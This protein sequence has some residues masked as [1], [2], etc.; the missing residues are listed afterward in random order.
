MKIL[1]LYAFVKDTD[2]STGKSNE[3]RERV[4]VLGLV[5]EIGSVLS[6]LKKDILSKNTDEDIPEKYLVAGELKE[7]IGDAIWYTIMLALCLDDD[8][9]ANDIFTTDLKMLNNQLTGSKRDDK[10]VQKELGDQKLHSFLDA[11]KFYS[12]KRIPT[13]N[14]Y[15]QTAYHTRRTEK[16]VLRNVCSA[17]LQQLAAQL[18]RDF[19][20]DKEMA[21][22]HEI[23]P[24]DPVN[25]L[26]EILW[27]LAA[28]A[29][30]YKLTLSEILVQTQKKTEFRNPQNIDG[31]DHNHGIRSERFPNQFQVHFLAR[32]G[33][34]TE[35][36]WV[37]EGVVKKK[38][39]ASLTDNNHEGDGYRFHDAIHVAFAVHLR[40]SPNLRSFMGLKRRSKKKIDEI[41]DGG[42]AKILEEAIILEIHLQAED[43]LKYISEAEGHIEG[44]P[45]DYDSTL[46]FPFLRRLNKLTKG[47]E[48]EKNPSQDWIKA[49]RDGYDCYCKLNSAGGGILNADMINRKI[50][51]IPFTKTETFDYDNPEIVDED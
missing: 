34:K 24:K 2:T 11:F 20:P 44:S 22:N 4:A 29:S 26:G 1:D 28:L 13:V 12:R 37:H 32:K 42:R 23:R 35:M 14:D 48:V 16:N 39:G 30:I 10:R 41:E 15:Q 45:Y 19:L 40:W 51:Y 17:V 21:L 49:I 47:H 27:H 46:N 25:A 8:Q 36:Y 33:N 6:A 5:S 50:E 7:E 9:R 31:P 18:S 38:L 3:E 43:F